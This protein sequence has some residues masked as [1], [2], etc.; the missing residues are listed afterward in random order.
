MKFTF[1]S[2]AALL[3]ALLVPL[4]TF[5]QTTVTTGASSIPSLFTTV[6]GWINTIAVPLVFALAFVAFL[7][8]VY[9]YFIQ[10]AANSEKRK[11]GNQ[12]LLWSLIGFFVMFSVW[13]LINLFLGTLGFNN[14]SQPGLPTFNANTTSGTGLNNLFGTG[15]NGVGTNPTTGSS[16]L[17]VGSTVAPVNGTCQAGTTPSGT[18]CVVTSSNTVPGNGGTNGSSGNGPGDGT[19][20]AGGDCENNANACSSGN[21]CQMNSN[22]DDTCVASGSATGQIACDVG[23]VPAGTSCARCSDNSTADTGSDCPGGENN[24]NTPNNG[25]VG[26]GG[27][28]EENANACQ[29]GYVCVSNSNGDDYCAASNGY[30]GNVSCD[31]GSVPAGTSCVTCSDYSTADSAADC[32]SPSSSGGNSGG[33]VDNSGNSGS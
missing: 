23:S 28:C 12:F 17:P 32:P 7:F 33:P 1:A 24:A 27:D 9:Y 22:G 10:N 2:R 31:V 6:I 21:V 8:G 26:P 5:A 3:A 29:T 11:E 30:S 18:G 4:L 14:A 25:S 16:Y 19:L 13:G 20:N 15:T